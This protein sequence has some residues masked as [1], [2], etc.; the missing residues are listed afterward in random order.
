MLHEFINELHRREIYI[1]TQDGRLHYRAPPGALTP[2]IRSTLQTRKEEILGLLLR[3]SPDEQTDVPPIRPVPRNAALPLSYAQQRLWLLN[4]FELGGVA[5]NIAGALYLQGELDTVALERSLNEVVRRHESLRT[6]FGAQDGQ[7]IQIINPPSPLAITHTDLKQWDRTRQCAEVQR[8]AQE[9]AQRPFDLST[10]PL[11]RVALLALGETQEEADPIHVLLFTMHHIV[12][13]G[14]SAS[15]LIREFA[16]HYQAYQAGMQPSLAELPVQYADYAIWQRTVL[17]GATLEKHLAYWRTQLGGAAPLLEL[18]TD[19]QRPAEKGFRGASYPFTVSLAVTGPLLESGRRNGATLFMT[20]LAA[21]QLL[22]SRHSGQKDICVGSPIANRNRIEIEN[23]IGFFVNT[24]VYRSD[25]SGNPVFT[26]LLARVRSVCLDAQEHQ[27]LPFEKLVE[28]LHPVRDT[29]YSPLFQAMLVLQN[30][31]ESKLHIAGLHVSALKTST[32]SAKFD[33]TFSLNETPNGLDG[34]ITYATDLYEEST[35]ARLAEHYQILLAGIAARPEAR[36]SELPMLPEAERRRLL[37]EWNATHNN[38]ADACLHR[39][40]ETQAEQTPDALALRFEQQTLTYRELDSRANQLARFLQRQGVAPG[41]IV[42]LCVERSLEMVVAVLG[43]LKAGCAYLPLEPDYPQERLR[44]MLDDAEPALLLTFARLDNSLPGHRPRIFLDRDWPRIAAE[45]AA[46]PAGQTGPGSL[47]YV[48]YTSGSTGVPKGVAVTHGG[49]AGYTRSI[50]ERI[51]AAPG[52]QYALVSTFAAD[53]GNTVLFPALASGGCLHLIGRDAATDGH[54]LADYVERHPIDVLKIVP[55]HLAG[56]LDSSG[57]GNIAPRRALICGGDVLPGALVERIAACRPECRILNHYGP[58]ETTVGS[59]IYAITPETQNI[60]AQTAMPVGRPIA[61]TRVYILDDSLEPA[62]TGAAGELY[63]G[64]NGLAQGYLKRPDLTAERF[65]PDPFGTG[66]RLYRTG[67][68]VRYRP[69]GNIE[70][71]GRIDQQVKIRGYRIEPGEIRTRLLQYPHVNDAAVLAREDRSG[72]KRLVAYLTGPEAALET[73]ALRRYLSGVLPDYMVPSAFVRLE[74]LPLTANGKLDHRALPD[75]DFGAHL[76]GRYVA[77]RNETERRLAAIWAEVLDVERV[78]V[79]DN[80]FELGGHSLMAYRLLERIRNTLCSD[81][82]Y[83]SIFQSPTMEKLAKHIAQRHDAATESTV[84]LLNKGPNSAVPL[85]CF[86][87]SGGLVYPYQSLADALHPQRSVYGIQSRYFFG[88]N[89]EDPS[90]AGLADEYARVIRSHSSG[91]YLLLGWSMGG[92]LALAVAERLERESAESVAF[93]GLIDT[94]LRASTDT[95]QER[96]S[97]DVLARAL[98]IFD[99]AESL[100]FAN[101]TLI[102]RQ[103]LERIWT[104]SPEIEGFRHIAEW[105]KS[106]GYWLRDLPIE[107]LVAEYTEGKKGRVM[108]SNFVPPLINAPIHI[109]WAQ[110]A[111]DDQGRVPVDWGRY[112]RNGARAVIVEDCDHIGI[113][114]ADAM[115]RSLRQALDSVAARVGNNGLEVY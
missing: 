112:S 8:L 101:L 79:H 64:G 110:A 62:P 61:N 53:L 13:D 72:G 78:G 84:V 75:P 45:S 51:Q 67:D 36:L 69:D 81:L 102:E 20:L 58:T 42:G 3:M 52:L 41:D 31:P 5:Y 108:S 10:G 76:A 107:P 82:P 22:L 33:L 30:T 90:I 103:E 87:P 2:E 106:R 14:W 96:P 32:Q 7:P 23:L 89:Q 39:L 4:R 92:L 25:L 27:D 50:I 24:L 93:T 26:E 1:H 73:D 17:Q 9:E 77:P 98:D 43:V 109:W 18:P 16:T 86:H 97:L 113:I 63:I 105:G 59:L 88:K 115:H 100:A 83:S 29:R 48:I 44:S 37:V 28:E 15:I 55:A 80:F 12:S 65:I 66:E 94:R 38:C 111:L 19:R 91:P 56:L 99:K 47:A 49:I 114:K 57:H 71:L 74:A 11:I 6:C 104:E 60:A 70:Y 21:F 95:A 34:L 85:Y 40:F 68:R 35:I 46:C 54:L